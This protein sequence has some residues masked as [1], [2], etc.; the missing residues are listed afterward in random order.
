MTAAPDRQPAALT[1]Y[2][3][4]ACPVCSRE[5]AAYQRQQGAEACEWIDAATCPD[6]RLGPGLTRSTALA[7]F[8]V[9]RAD[10]E[11]EVGMRGFATLWQ[12]LPRT[13][14]LGRLAARGPMPWLLDQAYR[15]FLVLRRLWRPAPG[16][17]HRS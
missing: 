6:D 15:V 16:V 8:H 3:D 11:L 7:R 10:G 5:I 12:A 4:G 1:V 17:A 14:L 13:A 9:R 2:Y